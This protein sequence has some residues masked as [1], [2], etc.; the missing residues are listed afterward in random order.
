ME[1]ATSVALSPPRVSGES[2][3]EVAHS[4]GKLVGSEENHP[5]IGWEPM[6]H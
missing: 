5:F 4:Q 3:T 2:A 6:L 1:C